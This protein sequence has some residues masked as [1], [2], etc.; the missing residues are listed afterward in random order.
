[1]GAAAASGPAVRAV[2]SVEELRQ[3][4]GW[5]TLRS[6]DDMMFGQ[7]Q[8]L[9]DDPGRWQRMHWALDRGTFIEHLDDVRNHVMP[10]AHGRSASHR[11]TGAKFLDS[12]RYLNPLP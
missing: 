9:L 4:T 10:S 12:M 8:R 1:M 7:Y 3:L 5:S 2:F 6:V 11:R